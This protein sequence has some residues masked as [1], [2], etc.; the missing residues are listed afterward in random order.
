VT[1]LEASRAQAELRTELA[2][3]EAGWHA[4]A[5][6]RATP[7]VGQRAMT[8]RRGLRGGDAIG[9]IVVP[10]LRLRTVL[11]EGRRRRISPAAPATTGSRPCPASAAPSR[12]PDTGRRTSSRSATSTI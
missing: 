10:R 5:A 8:Y 9:S 3:R 4:T 2:Q 1:A 11:V 12:S 6:D 7:T